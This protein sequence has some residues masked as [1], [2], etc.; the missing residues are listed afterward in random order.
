MQKEDRRG[1][2]VRPRSRFPRFLEATV[3]LL[4]T[5]LGDRG[6]AHLLS[7][8][9]ELITAATSHTLGSTWSGH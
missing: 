7:D 4:V 3:C 2:D 1:G 6:V 8:L 9:S 5:V